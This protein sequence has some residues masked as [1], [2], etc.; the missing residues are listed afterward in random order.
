MRLVVVA[1]MVLGSAGGRAVE[2]RQ[3]L[4][5]AGESA[6]GWTAIDERRRPATAKS[7]TSKRTRRKA[8]P[9]GQKSERTLSADA[10]RRS[11]YA[12]Q[13]SRRAGLRAAQSD[14]GLARGARRPHASRRDRER[15]PRGLAAPPGARRRG[16]S[17]GPA[18]PGER[19]GWTSDGPLIL[20]RELA[21][22]DRHRAG[23][24][25]ACDRA[26][27]RR[28]NVVGLTP[29]VTPSGSRGP[30]RRGQRLDC[31][32]LPTRP[33]ARSSQEDGGS[34]RWL[35][36]KG[37][38]MPQVTASD[39]RVEI[40]SEIEKVLRETES[41]TL[42][43]GDNLGK[44][45]REA[46]QLI[47]DLKSRIGGLGAQGDSSVAAVLD[48]QGPHRQQVRAAA[49]R[50]RRRPGLGRRRVLETS[51]PSRRRRSP[52]KPSPCSRACWPSTR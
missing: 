33:A 18:E 30:D 45:V 1:T 12:P 36:P 13:G 14:R 52:F 11:A 8:R 23:E 47:D 3:T 5:C 2:A 39:P 17:E 7:R 10:C 50:H 44:V 9:V 4:T 24:G 37:P 42:S 19:C 40:E 29:R 51:G 22:Q 20:G 41:A 26:H 34:S 43:L 16:G 32:A 31:E 27:G 49:G 46:E 15:G 21:A 25:P 6:R 28:L 48:S 38:A 35:G